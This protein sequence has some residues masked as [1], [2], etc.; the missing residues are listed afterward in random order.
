M[1]FRT[2]YPGEEFEAGES[3]SYEFEEEGV[4]TSG[5]NSWPFA[6]YSGAR[7]AGPSAEARPARFAWPDD[8]IGG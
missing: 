6:E 7:R 1:S 4:V 8:Y 5:F 3:A 2:Q